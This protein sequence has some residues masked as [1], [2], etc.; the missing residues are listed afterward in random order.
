MKNSQLQ[1][2]PKYSIT[3]TAR[4]EMIISLLII[5]NLFLPAIAIV[6]NVDVVLFS[7]HS[8]E[9]YSFYD[10][11]L[12]IYEDFADGGS[13]VSKS[14]LE[15]DM[16]K[17]TIIFALPIANFITKFF[18]RSSWLSVLT[19]I[20]AIT[21]F[22]IYILLSD[23]NE[24]VKPHVACYISVVISICMYLSLL[25]YWG[26]KCKNFIRASIIGGVLMMICVLIAHLPI[27][28]SL[29]ENI[30]FFAVISLLICITSVT[31]LLV[32]IISSL[33]KLY[34]KFNSRNKE[35]V[36]EEITT[37]NKNIT[38]SDEN[39]S[40]AKQDEKSSNCQ[41]TTTS[42]DIAHQEKNVTLDTASAED[43]AIDEE[44]SLKPSKKKQIGIA[45]GVVAIMLIAGGFWLST[46]QQDD[47]KKTNTE[48]M[49][50]YANQL[51]LRATKSADTPEN[52]LDII[53][54]GTELTITN[55]DNKWAETEYNN[56]TGYVDINYL[57]KIEDFEI[58]EGVWGNE[59]SKQAV[60]TAKHRK[61]LIH[62][63]STRELSTGEDGWQLFT[64]P[65]NVTP[66]Y[67]YFPYLQN[68][69]AY[70][71]DM[72]FVFILSN[73]TTNEHKCAVYSFPQNPEIPV[74]VYEES[75]DGNKCIKDIT[76]DQN[77][78]KY[79]ISY[80]KNKTVFLAKEEIN[81]SNVASDPSIYG[82]KGN[83][84]R[85]EWHLY[86]ADN[87]WNATEKYHSDWVT[88]NKE[89][90]AT[91]LE[92]SDYYL[93]DGEHFIITRD[94]YGRIK[95]YTAPRE[96][97]INMDYEYD[98]KGRVAKLNATYGFTSQF[99]YTYYY[100]NNDRITKCT[101]NY[102]DVEAN[103]HVTQIYTY[104]EFDENGNWTKRHIQ[105]T[106][107]SEVYNDYDGSLNKTK[108]TNKKIEERKI[109]YY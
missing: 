87:N 20:S 13:L 100:D 51:N 5:A 72:D 61:A 15:P 34:D 85:M 60:S 27:S 78:H 86:K 16:L 56:Q 103:E 23:D 75:V 7:I 55:K 44:V 104:T 42:N 39:N 64:L 74:C 6:L 4:F 10:A 90:I 105:E 33:C 79:T 40:S 106:I 48:K 47:E 19:L 3:T 65:S 22:M 98:K 91:R 41:P 21:P 81:K 52:I 83:V 17:C 14:L 28:Y 54:Y 82:L 96:G 95:N 62:F 38:N 8:N 49:I 77:T 32:A 46:S 102:S 25:I 26:T 107:E 29:D 70:D 67:V 57:T 73:N 69:Q 37:S 2:T 108:S 89:G 93:S 58:L 36:A 11:F 18:C 97:Q 71:Y 31:F 76:Y 35:K 1:P 63:C 109:R 50:V 53:P 12:R 43:D 24:P 66:N 68:G 92:G 101:W 99:N 94:E 88:F 30:S 84:Q 59:N 80:E 9:S 45:I